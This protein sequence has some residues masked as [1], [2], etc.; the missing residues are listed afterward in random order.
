MKEKL[1]LLGSSLEGALL[2]DD[3]IKKLYA[4]D[5]SA[6]REIPVAVALPK[7]E[8]DLKKL[9]SFANE[10][11]TS[12]IPRTA[13]TS[14]A[15]QVV[16]GGIVV[17]VSRHF[18][19]IL[20]I[21][22]SEKWV[23][24]QP[25]V[26]RDDLNAHLKAYNLYFGPETSTANRAMIGGMVGNNS[27][28]SNSIIYGSTREHVLSI[29]ALLSDG[30]TAEFK[31]LNTKEFN[32]KCK[33]SNALEQKIYNGIAEMLSV[34]EHQ[35]SIETG[36][37]KKE[38]PRRNT[39]YALDL[40]MDA[41]PINGA[42]KNFN[43]CKLL[44]GSEGTLVI[45]TEIKLNLVPT[46]PKEKLLVCAHFET[47]NESLEA[48]LIA[49]KYN[50][51]ACELMD[52]YILECTKNNI[53]QQKNRFFIEG[54]P[55]AIL[56]VDLSRETLGEAQKDAQTM[57]SELKE[58]GFGYHYPILTGEETGK[59]WGLRKAGLGLLSNMKGDAKP[60]PVIEDTAVDVNELP[61]Y[62]KEFNEILKKH[63]LY[64]VHYAHAA[65]GELHLRPILD[66]K[67]TKGTRQFRTIA[68]EIALLVKKY[69]GSLSGEHGDGRLRGEFIKFMV[70]EENY[71]LFKQL[72][73]IWDP[74]NIFNPGKI[75]D[76]PPMDTSLRYKPDKKT[77]QFDT[78]YNFD[79][80][81]GIL[82]T[83]ELCNGSGDCRKT[84][85]SGGTMCPSYMATKDEKDTTRARANILREIL[86]NSSKENPFDSEEIKEVMD[87]C[88][89]C[90]GCT[91][92]CPSNVDMAKLKG[93]FLQ[94]YYK[95]NGIP[96][97]T[98]LICSF[99]RINNLFS[100]MPRLYN[101]GISN[102][103]TAPIIKSVS[104]FAQKRS[105]PRMYNQTLKSWYRKNKSKGFGVSN[106]MSPK[107][108]VYLFCDEF[109]N[110]ND[111]PVGIS[112]I[113]LLT[114]LGFDVE[115]PAHYESGR[116]YL[117]KGLIKKAKALATKNIALLQDKISEETPL[118]GIE[119]SAIL[120]FRDEYHNFSIGTEQEK[121]VEK[122]ANSSLMI[123]E[124]LDRL[125]ESGEIESSTFDNKGKLIK[126]HGHCHQKSLASIVPTKRM[127]SFPK[128]YKV[129]IIPSGCCG[130]AGSF[131]YEKEHY[132][133]S[134][135]IGE[136][137]LFPT[138]RKQSEEVIIAAP[139]TSCRHQIKDGTGKTAKHPVEILWEAI[140][141]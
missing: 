16:G 68:E 106:P 54:D 10:H 98:K 139:G 22:E 88:I 104:G 91:S 58:H 86:T 46:P 4:T 1:E 87:L 65:T 79:D 14:L 128:N 141:M 60:A 35:K 93:E 89:S 37:P 19:K 140:K 57:I 30:S 102:A 82:R 77:P 67:T 131:G 13:G 100:K 135:Q 29:K 129:E 108:K 133:V 7:T 73:N 66:L 110:F 122:L 90:K 50:P 107:G 39:G 42:D 134:M 61:S 38:I 125:F 43:F 96:L 137:V 72:K 109:T 80:Y 92:E 138:I 132:D 53:A 31:E 83:A 84:H 123:D 45:M 124:F 99:T 94:Q 103:L 9:I 136:L 105:L 69:N 81:D 101:F 44:A 11:N 12:L 116:T 76:T 33:S 20:E 62:I 18:T 117:S 3:I 85:V 126:L 47:I 59:I 28:G 115:I 24:V 112:A 40:L 48:N 120:S 41:K 127:L 17:D 75:V 56:V 49:L 32:D 55:G 26:V 21:N 15:G 113:R 70:G 63:G 27:C 111:A 6:Y 34:E 118:L 2:F 114:K 5:A 25:G 64:S 52:H 130:M 74:N 36:F 97:R 95:T 119:P 8:S 23:R 121:A 78:V 71:Q 51:L